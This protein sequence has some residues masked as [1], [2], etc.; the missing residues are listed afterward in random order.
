MNFK[1]V[2]TYEP[3]CIKVTLAS[4]VGTESGRVI[5]SLILVDRAS[6]SR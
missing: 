1:Q 2:N 6:D 5:N 4:S 3:D